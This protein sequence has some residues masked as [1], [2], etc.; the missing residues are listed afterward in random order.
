MNYLNIMY[1][2]KVH[3]D[4]IDKNL[5]YSTFIRILTLEHFYIFEYF[6]HDEKNNSDNSVS[7]LL[8]NYISFLEM[9]NNDNTKFSSFQS[10]SRV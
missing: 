5:K 6:S 7:Y 4:Y 1:V 8:L 3:W 10:L 2:I 9:K